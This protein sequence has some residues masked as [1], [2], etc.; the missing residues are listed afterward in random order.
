MRPLDAGH[1][2]RPAVGRRRLVHEVSSQILQER[3]TADTKLQAK[4]P[5][6]LFADE[7]FIDSQAAAAFSSDVAAGMT[8]TPLPWIN[9]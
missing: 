8:Y 7:D 3:D 1:K 9:E 5:L 2:G 4:D 6:R